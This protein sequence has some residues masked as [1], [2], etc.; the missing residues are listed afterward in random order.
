MA[1]DHLAISAARTKM[2][3]QQVELTKIFNEMNKLVE[4]NVDNPKVWM[5]QS[6]T[7][8]KRKWVDFAKDFGPILASFAHQTA[9]VEKAAF[10]YA[11]VEEV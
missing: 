9:I 1:L 2:D 11:G 3:E 10:E 6:A 5:G 7:D 8:F 4:E